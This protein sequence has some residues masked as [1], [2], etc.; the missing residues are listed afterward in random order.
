MARLLAMNVPLSKT[1]AKKEFGW[2]PRFPSYRES[3]RQ[4][5]QKAA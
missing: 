3:L 4:I 5:L 2:E 1:K